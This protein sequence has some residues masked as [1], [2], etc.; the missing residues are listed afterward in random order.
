[1]QHS[2]FEGTNNIDP[3]KGKHHTWK[4]IPRPSRPQQAKRPRRTVRKSPDA[5]R[6][7]LYEASGE[8][9]ESDETMTTSIRTPQ[10]PQPASS[11]LPMTPMASAAVHTPQPLLTSEENWRTVLKVDE[12]TSLSGPC[13]PATPQDE[14]KMYRTASTPNSSFGQSLHGLHLEEDLDMKPSTRTSSVQSN[15]QTPFSGLPYCQ[16]LH[17]A[18]ASSAYNGQAY[19]PNE[20]YTN[21]APSPFAPAAPAPAFINPFTMYHTPSP[22]MSYG[23]YAPPVPNAHAFTYEQGMFSSTPMSYPNTPMSMP[24]PGQG[25]EGFPS[26]SGQATP[27]DLNMTFNGPPSDYAVSPEELQQF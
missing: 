12:D 25:P 18:S 15:M 6:E 21:S 5:V 3:G 26:V 16:P 1:M 22:S 8:D 27:S 13:T 17:Y 10:F 7:A 4:L 19:R 2:L 20:D 9:T 14:C 23:Q 11:P 24:A